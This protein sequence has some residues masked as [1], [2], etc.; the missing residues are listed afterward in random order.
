MSDTADR[1]GSLRFMLDWDLTVPSIA[2]R[3]VTHPPGDDA[4]VLSFL[5][6]RSFDACGVTPPDDGP[7]REIFVL[8]PDGTLARQPIAVEDLVPEN[9]PL[10]RALRLLAR[11]KRL[12]VLRVN[13]LSICTPADLAK[14]PAALV[15]FGVLSM[16]EMTLT[17]L[18]R[19]LYPGDTWRALLTPARLAAAVKLHDDRLKRNEDIDLAS[20]LQFCDKRDLVLAHPAVLPAWGMTRNAAEELCKQLERLRNN[21]AHAQDPDRPWPEIADLLDAAELVIEANLRL[22]PAT[23]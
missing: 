18:L 22:L 15:I 16:F 6:E 7:V 20:C 13:G 10:K 19:A 9:L 3:L 1:Y 23:G 5:R 12:F 8:A 14:P 2:E 11:R 4:T 17:D 21:L